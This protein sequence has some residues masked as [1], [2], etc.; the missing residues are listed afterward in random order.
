MHAHSR[1]TTISRLCAQTAAV[2]CVWLPGSKEG[3]ELVGLIVMSTF[4]STKT[5]TPDNACLL[6]AFVQYC[7]CSVKTVLVFFN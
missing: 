4:M 5:N 2:V 7:I 3:T 6:Y 1:V